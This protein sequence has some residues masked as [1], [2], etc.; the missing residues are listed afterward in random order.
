MFIL[1]DTILVDISVITSYSIHYT[2]LYDEKSYSTRS[3]PT[4]ARQAVGGAQ[5]ELILY[6]ATKLKYFLISSVVKLKPVAVPPTLKG[7]KKLLHAHL[8]HPGALKL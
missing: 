8:A 2:K 4:K 3:R 5:N 1:E 6:L 7:Q